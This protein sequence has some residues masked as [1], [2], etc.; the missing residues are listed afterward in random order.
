LLLQSLLQ[1][2]YWKW[3]KFAEFD[4]AA[5]GLLHLRLRR[6]LRPRLLRL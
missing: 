1:V 6:R 3:P 2:R 5:L 4:S